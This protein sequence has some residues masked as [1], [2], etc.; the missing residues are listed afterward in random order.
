MPQD[1][2]GTCHFLNNYKNPD[3]DDNES[4]DVHIQAA[5]IRFGINGGV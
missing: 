1:V 5:L 3:I 4:M 2:E